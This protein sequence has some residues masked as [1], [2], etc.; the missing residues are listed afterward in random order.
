MELQPKTGWRFPERAP[1]QLEFQPIAERCVLERLTH[2]RAGSIG[3]D[4]SMQVQQLVYGR[5]GLPGGSR[6][7]GQLPSPIGKLDDCLGSAGTAT[8]GA[9]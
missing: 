9:D 6:L 4:P 3:A 7:P 2:K 5:T 1:I 8:N